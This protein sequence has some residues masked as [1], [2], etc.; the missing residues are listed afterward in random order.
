MTP[1]LTS[2]TC[3]HGYKVSLDCPVDSSGSFLSGCLLQTQL[4][5]VTI[6]SQDLKE[7]MIMNESIAIKGELDNHTSPYLGGGKGRKRHSTSDINNRDKHWEAFQRFLKDAEYQVVVDAA[8][9]GYYKQSQRL[10]LKGSPK[11]VD[12]RQ[13]NAVVLHFK[14]RKQKSLLILHERH[15][16]PKLM[17]TWAIPIVKSWEDDGILYKVP[18]GSND[19]LYWLHAALLKETNAV[20]NDEMRD[21]HFMMHRHNKFLR[22]KERYQIHFHIKANNGEDTELGYTFP[23]VYSRRIQAVGGGIAIPL[24]R[25]GDQGRFLDGCFSVLE[26]PEQETY[27]CVSPNLS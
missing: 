3:A 16:H 24:P 19:D 20:T 6:S 4:L 21:H 7:I 8:N 1:I 26:G 18:G 13:I 5:P 23:D 25:R 12:Y 15:F 14:E 17:P 27:M 22:W 11:H 2:V 10:K 9:V